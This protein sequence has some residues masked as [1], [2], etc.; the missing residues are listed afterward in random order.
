MSDSLPSTFTEFRR[1]RSLPL[2]RLGCL[3]AAIATL[4]FVP[5]DP[6]YLHDPV[7]EY[8]NKFRL[9]YLLP[10]IIVWA[11]VTFTPL[12]KWIY[13]IIFCT[14]LPV[15]LAFV[16][17]GYWSEDLRRSDAVFHSVDP[18][19]LVDTHPVAMYYA[20]IALSQVCYIAIALFSL[21]SRYTIPFGVIT[22]GAFAFVANSLELTAP[23]TILALSPAVAITI[24]SL[25]TAVRSDIREW[26]LFRTLKDLHIANANHVRMFKDRVDYV[27]HET[28]TSFG[29]V[30]AS[31]FLLKHELK[32]PEELVLLDRAARNLTTVQEIMT[33]ATEANS[34]ESAILVPSGRID[35]VDYIDELVGDYHSD[36]RGIN[37][38]LRKE[39]TRNVYQD[40]RQ[41]T[42]MMQNLIENA[43]RYT[44]G[45]SPIVVE[46]VD[47]GKEVL[48][49]VTNSG[50][51]L[52]DET[53]PL[54]KIYYRGDSARSSGMGL[55]LWAVKKIAEHMD[56]RVY[57]ESI[58]DPAG[59]RFTV[60]LPHVS[61]S[62]IRRWRLAS[63]F[64]RIFGS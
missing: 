47:A 38:E 32:D 27:R 39:T 23:Q 59:A 58:L 48:F 36:R 40:K 12:R 51:T 19:L 55:G 62:F 56:G 46:V 18:A 3:L 13:G 33:A 30:D 10:A 1:E 26:R 25:V 21:P 57:A 22:L 34:I 37:I 8:M 53:A 60:A 17:A 14:G 6:V 15:G 29:N 43:V 61:K 63:S 9:Q 49:Q 35:V 16:L 44:D 64:E 5:V 28:R 45:T 7:A 11:L 20:G 50:E 4:A 31:L 24:L 42:Q 2:V 41:F 54:F 52:P